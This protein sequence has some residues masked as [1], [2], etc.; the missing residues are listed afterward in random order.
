MS[1]GLI[2]RIILHNT[3]LPFSSEAITILRP[4]AGSAG[5]ILSQFCLRG[6]RFIY[7]FVFGGEMY[8][9]F[10]S[11]WPSLSHSHVH[12]YTK[13]KSVSFLGTIQHAHAVYVFTKSRWNEQFLLGSVA[14]LFI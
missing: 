2:R 9:L 13:G 8:V 11:H 3:A 5:K 6:F 1:D 12:F 7:L 14:V 4:P 10:V